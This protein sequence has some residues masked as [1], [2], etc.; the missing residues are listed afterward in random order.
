MII[1]KAIS[2]LQK[3]Y[4]NIVVKDFNDSVNSVN[5]GMEGWYYYFDEKVR[6][7]ISLRWRPVSGKTKLKFDWIIISPNPSGKAEDAPDIDMVCIEDIWDRLP[8]DLQEFLLRYL[9]LL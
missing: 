4:R 3:E 6:V 1:S 8:D 5:S 7:L 9:E 2:N